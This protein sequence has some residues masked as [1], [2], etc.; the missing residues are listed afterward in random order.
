MSN[1]EMK[2]RSI[3]QKVINLEDE[4]N[5]YITYDRSILEG[6]TIIGEK[7]IVNKLIKSYERDLKIDTK[8]GILNADDTRYIVKLLEVLRTRKSIIDN[9]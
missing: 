2:V 7:R 1:Y 3:T 4:T 6:L 9:I 8:M 5:Q